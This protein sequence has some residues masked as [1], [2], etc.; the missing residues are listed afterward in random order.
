MLMFAALEFVLMI[1]GGGSQQLLEHFL[2]EETSQTEQ[3]MRKND[4]FF[5]KL[6]RWL[7]LGRV[8]LFVWMIVLLTCYSLLGLFIQYLSSVMIGKVFSA[9]IISPLCLILCLPVVRFVARRTYKL[10]PKHNPSAMFSEELIGCTATIVLGN[11]KP[12]EPAQ[13]KVRD[14]NGYVHYILVEPENDEVFRQG[15]TVLLTHK[16]SEGFQAIAA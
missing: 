6:L 5:S 1:L 10:L 15:Q 3:Q 4:G 7:Y 8:P 14:N 9:W 13:A 16:T 2:P 11:T 12:Q